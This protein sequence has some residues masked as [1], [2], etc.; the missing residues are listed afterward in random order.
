MT[1][2]PTT[3]PSPPVTVYATATAKDSASVSITDGAS[4]GDFAYSPS[5][6]TVTAGDTVTWTNN[7]AAP[8]GHTVTGSGF[9]SG[10]FQSGGTYSH[11]FT[12][13]GTFSYLCSIHPSMK[14]T[15]TV[16]AAPSPPGGS[17]GGGGAPT[18]SNGGSPPPSSDP[19]TPTTTGTG[20]ESA[21]VGSPTAAGTASSLPQ[22]GSDTI[23]LAAIGLVLLAAGVAVAV[24]P[25][26]R[27]GLR[28]RI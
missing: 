24:T 13:A 7:S 5:S 18:G 19:T 28:I 4:P 12:T 1:P 26:P 8:E 23:G 22:T 20:S 6:I 9:N 15:V 25:A 16:N 14:G 21:A 10:S 11:A 27:A 2:P 17:N 3:S